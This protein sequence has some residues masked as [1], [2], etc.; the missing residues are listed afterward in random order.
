MQN[1]HC[2]RVNNR[3]MCQWVN[4]RSP[5]YR[6]NTVV[7][8]HNFQSNLSTEI[9]LGLTTDSPGCLAILLSLS[10]FTFSFSF[11]HFLVVGSVR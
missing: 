10:V 8:F 4:G 1:S 3:S 2:S 11:F 6:Y 7:R 5:I 9:L